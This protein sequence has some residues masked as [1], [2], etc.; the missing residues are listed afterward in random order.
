MQFSVLNRSAMD[1]GSVFYQ[2]VADGDPIDVA[3]TEARGLLARQGVNRVD[4]AVPVLFLADP[5]CLQVDRAAL[6]GERFS[7]PLDLTGLTSAQSFV[8]RA[9]ELRLL[10]KGL[11]PQNG[12]WRA[13]VLHGLG[14]MG[15]TVLAARLAERMA[16]RLDGVTSLRMSPVTTARDVIDQ[17]TAFLQVRQVVFRHPAIPVLLATK[18]QP[19]PLETKAAPLCEIL[20]SL[21][22]LIVFDN[23][24]DILPQ[25]RVIS[26]RA[27]EESAGDPD[28]LKLIGLLLSGVPGPSR[29]LFTSR[30]DFSPFEAGRLSNA[31]GHLGLGEMQFRDAVYLM[32]TLPPLDALPVAVLTQGPGLVA[33]TKREFYARL[34]GHPYTLG[35]FAEHARRSSP[36][37]VLEN[38]AGVQKEVLDF[39]LLT[40]AAAA[41]PERAALLLRRAAVYD[42]AVPLEGL[43]VLLGDERDAMPAVQD[44]IE[45]LLG[46]GLLAR[47]PGGADYAIHALVRDWGRAQWTAEERLDLLHRAAGYWSSIELEG[48][49]VQPALNARHYLFLAGESA[50]A[51]E[52]VQQV[53]DA[54][55]RWGQIELLLRLLSE[56]VRTVKGEFRAIALG[57]RAQ[58]YQAL[59]EYETAR[60]DHRAALTVFEEHGAK[61][62]ISPAL[63]NLGNLEYLQ[64]NLPAALDFYER[65][66][67]IE[68]E[69]DYKPGIAKGLHQVG[70]VHQEQGDVEAARAC[71]EQS[72]EI[73]KET[74]DRAG[75]ALPLHQ[76]GLLHLSQN[77]DAAAQERF[78]QALAVFKELGDRAG[79]ATAQH[80]LGV[81]NQKLGDHI[82]ARDCYEESLKISEELGDKSGIAST[83][84]ELGRLLEK[85]GDLEHAVQVVMQAWRLF[86]ELGSPEREFAARDLAR[87]REK[88]RRNLQ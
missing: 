18:D 84:G 35:L 15:K 57:T 86:D 63:L 59:G 65:S 74:E 28:L 81:L 14:G 30:V 41:L 44:E 26:S 87:L 21:R 61:H 31:V 85:E 39:T 47:P 19:L 33:A 60:R 88:L 25:G 70:V 4:F 77:D 36:E 75:M 67:A 10:Q 8:G 58:V 68:R 71:Y 16:P 82:S 29:F 49:D 13:A 17:L 69:L 1:L 3:L 72:L 38:L 56:S 43:S 27:E 42:E 55:F 50:R 48:E 11:D 46:W 32:E 9:A 73:A 24:E 37:A 53:F 5:C 6:Q 23:C 66:L 45:A 2:G 76:L 78:E 51:D 22:L 12:T 52:I 62:L 83:L 80:Q 64:G 34:G 7:T 54:L 79:I 40:R 20:R